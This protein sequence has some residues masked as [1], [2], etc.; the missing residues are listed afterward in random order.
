D[1]KIA[2]V[3]AQLMENFQYSQQQFDGSI[4]EKFFNEYIGGMSGLDPRH[5]N[6][7]QSDINEFSRYRTNLDLYTIGNRGR[8]DLE[9]AYVIYERFKQR[10]TQHAAYVDELLKQNK[11][12]FTVDDRIDLD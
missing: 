12:N 8:A 2:Y 7:L 11:L 3:T 9:P 4:S 10:L 5:E 1:A 6:F